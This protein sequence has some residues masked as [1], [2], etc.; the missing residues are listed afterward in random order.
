MLPHCR[1]L[2]LQLRD[3][4][5]QRFDRLR[6]AHDN[7]NT[8]N[9][10]PEIVDQRFDTAEMLYLGLGIIADIAAAAKRLYQPQPFIVPERV[11]LDA[12]N[13]GSDT[14]NVSWFRFRHAHCF[15][16]FIILYSGITL[17]RKAFLIAR[18]AVFP[19]D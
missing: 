11:S 7:L 2:R 13:P 9:I 17:F 1:N 16:T 12:D 5:L 6:H 15:F 4:L 14:D 19:A 10:D 3:A 18:R 8:G